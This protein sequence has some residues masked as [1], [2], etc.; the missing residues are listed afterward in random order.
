MP[1]TVRYPIHGLQR[2][3]KLCTGQIRRL[4]VRAVEERADETAEGKEE[5]TEDFG[6]DN[7]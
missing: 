7:K 5:N 4:R 2:T 6:E 1:E 3:T